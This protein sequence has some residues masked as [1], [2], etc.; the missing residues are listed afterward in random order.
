MHVLAHRISLSGGPTSRRCRDRLIIIAKLLFFFDGV[1]TLN[2]IG[3]CGRVYTTVAMLNSLR[4]VLFPKIAVLWR[5]GIIQARKLAGIRK[6]YCTLLQ[7]RYR[8]IDWNWKT[9][10]RTSWNIMTSTGVYFTFRGKTEFA[11]KLVSVGNVAE[12]LYFVQYST[13][14]STVHLL[15]LLQL[16]SIELPRTTNFRAWLNVRSSCPICEES[17]Y[18]IA[19]FQT[20]VTLA[21]QAFCNISAKTVW[22]TA[23]TVKPAFYPTMWL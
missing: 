10:E 15:G 4:R 20:F 22:T 1:D 23:I 8:H 12:W 7:K 3:L 17:A 21:E 18:H 6:P 2:G 19:A 16:H 14:H 5:V 11:S 13:V 9:S